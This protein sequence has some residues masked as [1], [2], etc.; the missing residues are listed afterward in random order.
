LVCGN[1]KSGFPSQIRFRHIRSTFFLELAYLLH[2]HNFDF[3]DK[4]ASGAVSADDKNEVIRLAL[5]GRDAGQ[6]QL[7]MDESMTSKMQYDIHRQF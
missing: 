5:A 7:K 4:R 3:H 2:H 6:I 1:E